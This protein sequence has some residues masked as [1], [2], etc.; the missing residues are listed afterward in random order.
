MGTSHSLKITGLYRYDNKIRNRGSNIQAKGA[1]VIDN[2][3]DE[4]II[5]SN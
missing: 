3:T 2:V 1:L 4:M 5:F